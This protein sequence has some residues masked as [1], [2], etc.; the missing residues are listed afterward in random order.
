MPLAR[1]KA[2]GQRQLVLATP[3]GNSEQI[4]KGL[5][6]SRRK[7]MPAHWPFADPPNTAV[8]TTTRIVSNDHAVLR[9]V[10]Q[11][12]W[13]FLDDEDVIMRDALVVGLQEMLQKDASLELL[14]DLP[15]GWQ[16]KRKTRDA[17]WQRSP[18]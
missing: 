14:A 2:N 10:H 15:D 7:T 5:V 17:P 13:Q 1:I 6:V 9:I 8:I 16:A 3:N 18:L 4:L 12:G 11:E